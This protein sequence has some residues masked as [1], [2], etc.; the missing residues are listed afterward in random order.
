MM[1]S[2]RVDCEKICVLMMAFFRRNTLCIARK[3][4]EIRAEIIRKIP[5]TI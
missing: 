2:V 4:D 5:K 3:S 1:K